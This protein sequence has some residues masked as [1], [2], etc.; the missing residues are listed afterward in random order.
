MLNARRHL[1]LT[2]FNS[3]ISHQQLQLFINFF[4]RTTVHIGACKGHYPRIATFSKELL[5]QNTYNLNFLSGYC[6]V[7]KQLLLRILTWRKHPK[8][9]LKRLRKIR[10]WTF[11]S[12][13]HQINSFYEV[14][15][16]EPIFQ[17]NKVVT[18][19]T[20]LF[21]KGPL[22]SRHSICVNIGF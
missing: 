15:K 21:V 17:K 7:W 1:Q 9:K 8:I 4:R 22:C 12:L 5:F 14:L 20:A 10:I 6:S 13:V 16:L 2:H 19:K 3:V 18:G 11:G